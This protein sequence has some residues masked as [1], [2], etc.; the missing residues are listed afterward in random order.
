DTTR[1][2]GHISARGGEEGGDGGFAE[3]SGKEHLTYTGH[4]D[5]MAQQGETGTL[6]LDPGDIVINDGAIDVDVTGTG[7]SGAPF[8]PATED[9]SL[10]WSTILAAL[11]DANV[12]ITTSSAG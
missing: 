10:T 4:T 9:S 12:V 5:L 1:F 3:V 2:H 7:D 8:A 11:K 6:L